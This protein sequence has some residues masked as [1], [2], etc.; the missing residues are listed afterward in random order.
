MCDATAQHGADACRTHRH[1]LWTVRCEPTRYL[2]R[3]RESS[4]GPRSRDSS[5]RPRQES[6]TARHSGLA[7]SVLS[8]IYRTLKAV[9]HTPVR[10]TPQTVT[11][12]AGRGRGEG[13]R[14]G[15]GGCRSAPRPGA[16]G[17]RRACAGARLGA[18][19]TQQALGRTAW[20]RRSGRQQH[21]GSSPEYGRSE[22]LRR[23]PGRL[24]RRGAAH[25][26]AP[27]ES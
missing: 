21:G 13:G 18:G 10:L 26:P 6:R 8:Q 12:W 11:G 25:R 16:D 5:H 14:S 3:D 19:R 23:A 1:A 20:K 24:L 17:K 27:K 22:S 9:T 7:P 2:Y 15:E 4:E